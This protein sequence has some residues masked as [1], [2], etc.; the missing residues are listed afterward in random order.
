[1]GVV[2]VYSTDTMGGKGS[3]SKKGGSEAAAPSE[4]A[5][6]MELKFTDR[7]K[8]VHTWATKNGYASGMPTFVQRNDGDGSIYGCILFK[9]E[10]VEIRELTKADLQPSECSR[11]LPRA[12]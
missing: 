6:P 4:P 9:A 11:T 7:F 2:G 5:P 10:A 8:A 3:K 1:M 12:A